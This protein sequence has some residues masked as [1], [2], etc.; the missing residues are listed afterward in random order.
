MNNNDNNNVSPPPVK[1]TKKNGKIYFRNLNCNNNN[2]ENTNYDTTKKEY[3]LYE[4]KKILEYIIFNILN[5]EELKN[6]SNE[7]IIEKIEQLEY[8]NLEE[9]LN[10][11][12]NIYENIYGK[13]ELKTF[14][15]TEYYKYIEN[16][17]KEYKLNNIK[18]ILKSII[19][20]IIKVQGSQN[21]TNQQ[22]IEKI[23]Q[24]EYY[25]LE[26]LF[27]NLLDTY[28]IIYGE[29]E[30]KTFK[31]T[32]HYKYIKNTIKKYK[33]NQLNQI[34]SSLP[35]RCNKSNGKSYYTNK[36][37]NK[38]SN[39]TEVANYNPLEIINIIQYPSPLIN[40]KSINTIVEQKKH[41]IILS[42]IRIKLKSIIH[43]III[44]SKKNNAKI[45]Q[46]IY[47][48]VNKFEYNDL[49]QLLNYLLTLNLTSDLDYRSIIQEYIKNKN[50]YKNIKNSFEQLPINNSK[51]NMNTKLKKRMKIENPNFKNQQAFKNNKFIKG[52]K[53]QLTI[54]S[55]ETLC[56]S[57]NPDGS[58]L[59]IAKTNNSISILNIEEQSTIIIEKEN[60]HDFKINEISW[61]PNGLYIASISD[62]KYIKLW[63]SN[64]MELKLNILASS[65]SLLYISWSLDSNYL[66]YSSSNNTIRVIYI[67]NSLKNPTKLDSFLKLLTIKINTK[68]NSIVWIPN[69]NM[70]I[71][72][73]NEGCLLYDILNN[74][75]YIIDDGDIV[76]SI[77][78]FNNLLEN[79]HKP[80][81]SVAHNYET[82]PHESTERIFAF[83]MNE[84]I[85][86]KYF[87]IIESKNTFSKKTVFNFNIKESIELFNEQ[88]TKINS[89]SFSPDGKY[90]ISVSN[91]IQIWD[92][93]LQVCIYTS[94]FTEQLNNVI[95]NPSEKYILFRTNDKVKLLNFNFT[96]KRIMIHSIDT[97]KEGNFTNIILLIYKLITKVL[98]N[99]AEILEIPE[100][101]K[102]K[103]SVILA[104]KNK[105]SHNYETIYKY[106]KMYI[107]ASYKSI[108]QSNS[109]EESKINYK[110]LFEIIIYFNLSTNRNIELKT[111]YNNL[112]EKLRKNNNNA[113]LFKLSSI[114]SS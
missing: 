46:T 27:N 7:K 88:S 40:T 24:L 13:E 100:I 98:V 3:I 41:E 12:L 17:I 78:T 89:I 94:T 15:K 79:F 77:A 8:D 73:T 109:N 71:F 23:E 56:F 35:V 92:I 14:K 59:A 32:E 103:T 33:N 97:L 53:Q 76:N 106:I 80:S 61:S 45:V 86:I 50:P 57:L 6:I 91:K 49:E 29:N 114:F 95:W 36:K 99:Y 105:I 58:K 70:I 111:L 47:N 31:K 37:C 25:N 65:S 20:E 66:V 16:S 38:N 51:V 1:C 102:K 69:A 93:N 113:F 55:N 10:N 68:I 74:I 112:K 22:I 81:P 28:K 101:S 42:K 30:L 83:S 62:D 63:D 52:I 39:E 60:A 104:Q 87:V 54:I 107:D 110:N 4:I 90:I 75:K 85:I 18:E 48:S 43:K 82:T 26:E 84:K 44:S 64:T 21:I 9:V 34:I 96:L 5:F 108:S 2:T 67:E 72:G 19:F 11:I